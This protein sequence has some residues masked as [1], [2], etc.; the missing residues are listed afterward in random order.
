MGTRAVILPLTWSESKPNV[1]P[2][3][4]N[5]LKISLYAFWSTQPVPK[6]GLD[7]FTLLATFGAADLW[8]LD[9]FRGLNFGPESPKAYVCDPNATLSLYLATYQ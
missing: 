7:V 5:P 3:K 1:L 9:G 2:P 6:L 4:N 8:R